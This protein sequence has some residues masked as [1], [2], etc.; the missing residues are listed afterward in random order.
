MTELLQA[1]PEAHV[2]QLLLPALAQAVQARRRAG[3]ADRRA[4]RA[5]RRLRWRRGGLP[6]EALLWVRSEAAGRPAVGL[7]AGAALRRRGGRAGLAAAGAGGR[8]AAAAAGGGAARGAAV[9][10][11]ARERR[12]SRLRRRGCACRW[13]AARTTG[14]DRGPHPQAPRP[15]AGRADRA[16]GAQRAHDG[17]AGR[18]PAAA[19]AAPA[20]ARACAQARRRSATVVRIDACTQEGAHMHWIALAVAA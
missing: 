2:W 12:R 6:A 14:A 7:R 8:I 5:F 18:Q 9:R 1:A 15:A 19:Q 20:A 17:A 10:V 13:C 3:G 4:A 11:P 16:A